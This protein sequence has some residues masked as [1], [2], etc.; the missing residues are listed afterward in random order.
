MDLDAWNSYSCDELRK[1]Y[2]ELYK[3]Y[4]WRKRRM[5]KR[6]LIKIL[7]DFCEQAPV[8]RARCLNTFG[9]LGLCTRTQQ[10]QQRAEVLDQ[11]QAALQRCVGMELELCAEDDENYQHPYTYSRN[12][13]L[14]VQI[15][16]CA[17]RS[18]MMAW[19][20]TTVQDD[21]RQTVKAQPATRLYRLRYHPRDQVFAW[22][23]LHR[24]VMPLSVLVAFTALEDRL[25][26][27]A[28][29]RLVLC[30]VDPHA[31]GC[32]WENKAITDPVFQELRRWR[33]YPNKNPA[34]AKKSRA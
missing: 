24:M 3:H 33:K 1:L 32:T 31:N 13:R 19:D 4:T 30:Y 6:Q 9:Y 26:T 7:Q 2:D 16:H 17:S 18:Q 11:V 12:A 25:T 14:W 15:V 22:G 34:G 23:P 10:V 5:P 29:V 8:N 20:T 21:I 27:R 28:V